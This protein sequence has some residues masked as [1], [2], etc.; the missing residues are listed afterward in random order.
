MH[1]IRSISG[2]PTITTRIQDRGEEHTHVQASAIIAGSYTSLTLGCTTG[3]PLIE[4][5]SA[6]LFHL[7]RAH[8]IH[9]DVV[10]AQRDLTT[11]EMTWIV[12]D[13][14]PTTPAPP[15]EDANDRQ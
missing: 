5:H 3:I 6:A 15:E 14:H 11:D 10:G 9:G 13:E 2:W 4:Q 7:L 1:E 12:V 8:C